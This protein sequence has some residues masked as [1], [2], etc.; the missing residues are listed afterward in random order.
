MKPPLSPRQRQVL[1][2]YI[3]GRADKETAERLRLS[4]RTVR[5]HFAAAMQ[6]AQA[7]TRGQLVAEFIEFEED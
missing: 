1:R 5:F 2:E 7:R 6:K 3:A 4:V